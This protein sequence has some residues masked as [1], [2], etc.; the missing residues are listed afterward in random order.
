MLK[1]LECHGAVA[2]WVVTRDGGLQ[3]AGFQQ[4]LQVGLPEVFPVPHAGSGLEFLTRSLA[5]R[6][7][8]KHLH[9]L[10]GTCGVLAGSFYPQLGPDLV[11]THA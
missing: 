7:G 1:Q 4:L 6:S 9:D 8:D 3:Q 2:A 5:R 10:R 11:P